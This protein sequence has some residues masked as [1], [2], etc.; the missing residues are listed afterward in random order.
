[1]YMYNLNNISIYKNK[2]N[3][4]VKQKNEIYV[5]KKIHNERKIREIHSILKNK[6]EYYKIIPNIYN[7]IITEYNGNKYILIKKDLN[8]EIK[9]NE[10][11]IE[12]NIYENYNI[13][14]S[15]WEKLW[16][17]KNDYYELN[18]P[19]NRYL[20][21]SKEYYIGLAENALQFIKINNIKFDIVSITKLKTEKELYPDNAII[22]CKERE[23]AETI[24]YKFFFENYKTDELE[25]MIKQSDI[26][27]IIARL[28]YP[29][30]YF[31]LYD[32]FLNGKRNLE[33][34][35]NIITKTKKYE[36]FISHL[37][38][39][40]GTNDIIMPEWIINKIL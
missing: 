26:K 6:T 10:I 12:K 40:Y 29:N 24:K 33:Q 23:I 25:K 15:N 17:I 37:Y 34:V 1:M 32:E 20:L 5:L 22:D 39:K 27:K 38:K 11:H 3:I 13:N 36:K 30:Y 28:L 4:L 16:R 8:Y 35:T 2:S 14:H 9:S 19:T 31:D 7:D 18:S 21:E